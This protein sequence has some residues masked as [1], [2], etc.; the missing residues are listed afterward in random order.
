[1]VAKPNRIDVDVFVSYSSQ[2][3]DRV[4][5][6]VDELEGAGLDVWVDRHKIEGGTSWSTEIVQG[7][8]ACKVFVLI[9]SD[10]SM[11]S[12]NVKQEIQL[13]WT[14]E[15]PYLPLV[16]ESISYPDQVQYFLEGWQWV[17]ILDL[18][19]QRWLPRVLGALARA[20]IEGLNVD[21]SAAALSGEGEGAPS[22]DAVSADYGLEGLRAVARFT[23][24]IW[25]VPAD[26]LV[27]GGARP[28]LR[29]LGAP[30]E[31]VQ[32]GHAIGSRVGLAVESERDGYLLLLDE[33]PSGKIYCLCPSW[34][35]P[36]THLK[37]GR[38][39]LPQEGS[40]YDSFA[41]TGSPGREQLLAIITD[42]SLDLDWMTPDPKIPARVL[43]GRDIDLLVE[44]LRAFR[45]DCWT[46]LSTYFDVLA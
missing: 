1:M 39:Y 35:A 43:G 11:R 36:D 27:R 25:P 40:Q 15:K 20:G 23:D 18:P 4:L 12:R 37:A 46:A 22:V 3:R 19:P 32:H 24:Q 26:R 9:C 38:S 13:A 41:V 34:F 28:K 17:E 45:G 42:E 7:V 2:D 31:D 44:R 21:A 6:I 33:G 29:D 14:Y 10:A 5:P 16:L 30:Q 8:R